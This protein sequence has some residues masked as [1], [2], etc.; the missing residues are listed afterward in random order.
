MFNKIKNKNFAVSGTFILSLFIFLFIPVKLIQF[1]ALTYIF[2]VVFSLFYSMIL[3]RNID[4]Q[5]NIIDLKVPSKEKIEISFTVINKGRLPALACYAKDT[6]TLFVYNNEYQKLFSLRA[7][8]RYTIRYTILA[9]ERGLFY[10]GPVKIKTSDPLG[11]FPFEKEINVQ[12]KIL[13]RPA[14]IPVFSEPVPGRPQGN[15]KTK[16][17]I[18][19]DVTYRK[20]IKEYENNDEP[21]RINWKLSAKYGKLLTNQ[22]ENTFEV[23]FF[24]FL[25][26]AEEDYK[27]NTRFDRI[28]RAIEIAAALAQIA[29]NNRQSCGFSAYAQDFPYIPVRKNQT[30]LILD[31]LSLIK[32]APGKMN[33]DPVKQLKVQLPAE[34]RIFVIGP[35]NVEKYIDLSFAGEVNITSRKLNIEVKK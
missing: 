27:L 25:N 31:I 13:V 14:R 9:K 18:Y 15:I 5:R 21:K 1:I 20:S 7:F 33:Y 8:E 35:E 23:P 6:V 34:T 4:V 26:L 10:T 16:N 30:D 29:Q 17:I 24:I 28:E 32:M 19:E 11:L 12:N 22:Y 2:T 3:F